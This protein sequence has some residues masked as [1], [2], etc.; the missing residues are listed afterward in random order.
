MVE[1]TSY[2]PGTPSWVDL[3]SSDPADS[4]RFYNELFGWTAFEPPDGGGYMMFMQGDKRIAGVG[5]L[6]M[7]GQPEVWTTY[8]SVA[9]ADATTAAVTGAGGTVLVPPMDVV[10]AGRMGV[11][12]DD[13]GAAFSVWQPKDHIGADLVNE[14]VSLCWNELYSRD[15]D[16]SKAFYRAVFGWDGHTSEMGPMVYTEWKLAGESIGGMMEIGPPMPPGVP[17]H[18]LTYFAVADTDATVAKLTDLG[19]TVMM[20][21]MDIPPGRFAVVADPHGAMFA[22]LQFAAQAG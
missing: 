13:S 12:M 18:W 4:A 19:G 20:P 3:G 16:K 10:D 22:V 14:P 1:K 2:A 9:D 5:P 11:F 21:A 8:V 7:D 6:M 17:P 15:L